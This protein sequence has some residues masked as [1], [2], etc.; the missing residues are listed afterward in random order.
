MKYNRDKAFTSDE[1]LATF[2][3]LPGDPTLAV[4][5]THLWV[6]DLMRTYLAR[7]LPHAEA[8]KGARL[9]FVQVLAVAKA[10]CPHLQPDDWIWEAAARLNNI[11]N[12]LAHDLR[13][14]TLNDQVADFV[15]YW[16][17]HSGAPVP[18]PFKVELGQSVKDETGKSWVLFD[19]VGYAFFHVLAINLNI[20]VEGMNLPAEVEAQRDQLFSCRTGK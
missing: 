18:A 10:T 9:T 7:T 1:T 16:V 6:E 20:K 3:H 4:L 14:S 19:I 8:L 11:R 2:G 12:S 17:K 5:R 15:A 13:G